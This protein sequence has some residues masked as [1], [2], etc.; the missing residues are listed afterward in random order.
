[1]N[2]T[3]SSLPSSFGAE[4]A[5]HGLMTI[6]FV[7]SVIGCYLLRQNIAE[8]FARIES[9]T[10]ECQSLMQREPEFT[11]SLAQAEEHRE[12]LEAEYRGLLKRIPSQIDDS[13]ILSSL[14]KIAF[15]SHSNLI[16]FRPS[17][18]QTEGLYKTRAYSLHIEGDFVCLFRFFETL[19]ALPCAYQI[20]SA[21]ITEPGHNDGPCRLDMELKVVFGHVWSEKAQ[22]K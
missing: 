2:S 21:K 17:V 16:D 20:P 13:E 7:A 1:M 6:L 10:L 5:L 14:H 3:A 12:T 22:P 11:E 18:T 8:D 4:R 19:Q 15:E 9:D